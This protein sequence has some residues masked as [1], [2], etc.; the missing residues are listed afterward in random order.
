MS[1]PSRVRMTGPLTPFTEGFAA[2]L[3]RQGYRPNAAANQL[4]LMAHL[5]RW[6][7]TQGI[8][9]KALTHSVLDDFL[10]ARRTQ[11]YTLWR[12][13]KALIPFLAYW[14]DLG[15]ILATPEIERGPAGHLL[16]CYRNYLLDV[17]GLADST[18]REY[19]HMVR[20]FVQRR[21]V[22][23]ELDWSVLTSA[24]VMAFVHR[25]CQ[26]GTCIGTAKLKIT[27]LR[28]LLRYLHL[29]GLIRRALDTAVPSVAGAKLAGLPQSLDADEVERL[30]AACDRRAATSRR[31]FALL[32]LLVGLRLRAG[33]VGRLCLDDIDWRT[34]ELIVRGKGHRSDRMPLPQN[35]GEALAAY[36][37]RGRPPTAQGRTVFVR[38][39][40]PH[41]PLTSGGVT[42]AVSRAARKAGLA[43]VTA[44]RLR[45][46]VATRMVRAGVAL[47]EISQVLRHRQLRTTAIYA[48]LDRESL[49]C[50][51]RRWPGDAS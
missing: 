29:E 11:G 28:S 34:G 10:A 30:L 43:H 7:A 49:R 38:V 27:A 47:P 48:K 6:L 16:A 20:P 33:E 4:Q 9:A 51:A 13:P 45:H 18:A 32:M 23:G 35:V 42:D 21:V 41:R 37:R 5:S 50:L 25:A 24:D 15:F 8:E 2:E 26:R 40:A 19:V 22:D 1:D 14:R 44:H 36:L 17:R 3:A 39:R 31:D 12:S 46:T